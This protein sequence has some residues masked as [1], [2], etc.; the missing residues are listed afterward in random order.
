[1]TRG[2][3]K[4]RGATYVWAGVLLAAVVTCAQAQQAGQELRVRRVGV[5]LLRAPSVGS[6]GASEPRSP[7]APKRWAQIETQFETRPEWI[8]E[9]TFA[10]F[11]LVNTQD[12]RE[13]FMLLSREV[14]YQLIPRGRPHHSWLYIH[15]HILDRHGAVE[16]VAVEI[17]HRGQV[18]ATEASSPAH[19][20][21]YRQWR[22]Q[23]TP[24][25]GLLLLPEET[26]FS[27]F[28]PDQ[29]QLIKR[30]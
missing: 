14:T 18:I 23:L 7:G 8:D 28:A 24:R 25:T 17:Q 20:Q 16:G 15:P 4:R 9:L 6:P 26:P 12:P 11:V 3:S 10:Y 19:L 30:P 22:Q 1:M 2:T 21:Q 13:P 29:Q 5:N 27:L